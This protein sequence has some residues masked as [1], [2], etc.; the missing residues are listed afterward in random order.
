MDGT[1]PATVDQMRSAP[2]QTT[3]GLALLALGVVYGYIGTSTL[4]AAK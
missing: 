3:A 1:A 2:K 4:Y